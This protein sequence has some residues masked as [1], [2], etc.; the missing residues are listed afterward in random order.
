MKFSFINIIIFC[1]F[2][3]LVK[4][5][6]PYAEVNIDTNSIYIGEQV[7][8][9]LR[10]YYSNDS[11]KVEWPEIS[12]TLVNLVEVLDLSVIDT[13][14]SLELYHQKREIVITSF[15][16]G[17]YALKPFKFLVNEKPVESEALLLEVLNVKIDS[18]NTKLY[19]I[20]NIYNDPLTL[21]E[22]LKEY[23]PYLTGGLGLL[24]VLSWLLW[25]LFIRPKPIKETPLVVESKLPAHEIALNRLREIQEK[26]YWQSGKYKVY[27]SEVTDT[28]RTF[29]EQRFEIHALEQTSDEIIHQMKFTDINTEIQQKLVRMLRLADMVKFAKEKPLPAEN[30]ATMQM[31]I[32]FIHATQMDIEEINE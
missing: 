31:A 17:Y 11:D 16:S 20:K 1:L 25:F 22:F 19:D 32:D 21:Q 7:K 3:A 4:G 18:T 2:T 26:D 12:D 5:Q 28:I 6:S 15:D 8:I 14:R 9:H 29:M 30:E 10:I 24:A 23:W 13:S 27:H